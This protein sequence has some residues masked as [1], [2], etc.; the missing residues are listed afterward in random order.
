MDENGNVYGLRRKGGG[1]YGSKFLSYARKK[2][3][4]VKRAIQCHHRRYLAYIRELATEKIT[5]LPKCNCTGR[6]KLR[7]DIAPPPPPLRV[8]FWV[9]S[10]RYLQYGGPLFA[11]HMLYQMLSQKNYTT[12]KMYPTM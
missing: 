3:T 5:E 4:D 9:L 11:I 2:S 7:S 12:L 6:N 1:G 10:G 8:V